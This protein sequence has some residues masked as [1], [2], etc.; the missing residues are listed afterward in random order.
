MALMPYLE[1][2]VWLASTSILP[3]TAFPS[4]SLDNASMIG[5]SAR[6]GPHQVAQQSTSTTPLELT[7]SLKL[8]SLI[9]LDINLFLLNF[10]KFLKKINVLLNPTKRYL[11][12]KNETLFNYFAESTAT[13]STTGLIE[14]VFTESQVSLQPSC[15]QD[16]FAPQEATTKDTTTA[17]ANT[18]FFITVFF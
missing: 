7:V 4:Y 18:K 14:S 8:L 13:E 5:V 15:S 11:K 6:Q 16:F 3:I 10:N 9:S 17:N 12:N 1:A 2:I